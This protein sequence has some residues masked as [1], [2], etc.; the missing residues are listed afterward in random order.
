MFLDGRRLA[1]PFSE[2][3]EALEVEKTPQ[4]GTVVVNQGEILILDGGADLKMR[5]R[6]QKINLVIL[7]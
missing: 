5:N 6:W 2:G 3:R 1:I 4:T 7:F